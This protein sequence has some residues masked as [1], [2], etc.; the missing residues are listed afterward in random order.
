MTRPKSEEGKR[1]VIVDL[2]Y[3]EGGGGGV[4]QYIQPHQYNG[5][6]VQH[7]LPTISDLLDT[8]REVGMQHARM[9]VIDISRAY[10]HFPVCPLDW[11]L[12]VLAHN[13]EYYFDR[14]TPFG[15]RISSFVMQMA[16][17][18]VVRALAA[19]GISSLM[20]LD[21]LIIVSPAASAHH[22]YEEAMTL[23]TRLGFTLAEHK[24]Q[25]PAREVTWLGIRVD[26]EANVIAIP[27]HKLAE[28]QQGLANASRQQSLT[29]KAL[30]RVVGQINH[31]GKAVPPA[32]LFMG[33]LLAALRGGAKGR[34]RVGR[35]MR[36]DFAWFRRFLKHY[37]GRAIIPKQRR[38]RDIWV[39]A[40]LQGAGGTDGCRCYSYTFPDVVKK[41]HH[42]N[43]LEAINCLAA[44]RLF[45]LPGDAGDTIVVNCDNQAAVEAYRGGE[46]PRPNPVRMREGILVS[47][48]QQPSNI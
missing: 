32:R 18:F 9:A 2:S 34:I 19:K 44:A 8:I 26:L 17:D 45:T 37:N 7:A 39:D 22:H 3:P 11:P 43:H 48:R 20:Y 36:A 16:A 6:E 40:C 28:I 42:I 5:N 41:D 23:L 24:L 14:A 25:P 1:R 29:R 35:S 27:E 13:G 10:R 33:R 30:Q 4:N 12:L 21:D 15:A 38:R 31:L 46:S 47:E